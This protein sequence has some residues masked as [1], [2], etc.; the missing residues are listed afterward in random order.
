MAASDMKSYLMTS[1]DAL[2][3]RPAPWNAG[4]LSLVS[5]AGPWRE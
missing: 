3:S 4:T 1:N 2:G 5:S